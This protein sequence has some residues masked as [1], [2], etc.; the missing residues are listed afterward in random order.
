MRP[1]QLSLLRTPSRPAV[2]PDGTWAVVAIARPDMA[3]DSYPS[4]L[5]R[6]DL[7]N[8]SMRPLTHGFRDVEPVI[9]P[10]GR[11]LAFLRAAQGEKPQIALMPTDG[12][13]PRLLTDHP[14]GVSGGVEFAPD[15]GRIAYLD[16][17]STR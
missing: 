12:G 17:K 2:H 11:Y 6:L 16:R 10:D 15:S 13:E 5:W 9:S 8:G 1:E 3:E 7:S 4:Q 14:V